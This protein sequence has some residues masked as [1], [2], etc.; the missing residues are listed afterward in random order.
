MSEFEKEDD[1]YFIRRKSFGYT[2][3]WDYGVISNH[4]YSDHLMEMMNRLDILVLVPS[5]YST[6]GRI[7]HGYITTGGKGKAII[8]L[9]TLSRDLHQPFQIHCGITYASFDIKVLKYVTC[10]HF[11]GAVICSLL[12]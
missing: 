10:Q 4:K 8:R 9:V 3:L 11:K 2:C 6:L 12:L 7:R 1:S 5:F